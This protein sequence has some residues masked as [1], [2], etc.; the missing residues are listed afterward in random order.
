[1]FEVFLAPKMAAIVASKVKRLR[2]SREAKLAAE[3]SGAPESPQLYHRN[4]AKNRTKQLTK[5]EFLEQQKKI[6]Y[7]QQVKA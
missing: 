1:M 4:G 5:E 7:Y 6:R 2:V 3:A